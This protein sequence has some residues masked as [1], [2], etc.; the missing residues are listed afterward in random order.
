[1]RAW[2]VVLTASPHKLPCGVAVADQPALSRCSY[3]AGQRAN[4]IGFENTAP[5]LCVGD[6]PELGR[7]AAECA[8][9]CDAD[10]KCRTFV[11]GEGDKCWRWGARLLAAAVGWVWSAAS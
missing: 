11:H 9:A 5:A 3:V 6:C 4:G 2:C 7:T 10:D 1:M 8:E